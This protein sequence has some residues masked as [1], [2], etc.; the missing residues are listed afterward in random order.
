M[1]AA[2]VVLVCALNVLGRSAH[3]LPPITILD[4]RPPGV[5]INA[6][7]FVDRRD[8]VIYMISTAPAFAAAMRAH[9]VGRECRDRDTLRLIAS[10][11]VHEEWHFKN[12]SDER[13]AYATQ[14][15]ELHK[16]GLGPGSWAYHAVTRAMQSVSKREEAGAPR[17]TILASAR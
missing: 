12:G 15:T 14:L 17:P 7:A 13:G 5:S 4:A 6:D 3:T 10:I 8:G 9:R 16:L 1:S 2:A 11:I